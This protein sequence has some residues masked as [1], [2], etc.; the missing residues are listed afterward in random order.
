VQSLAN[1][2]KLVRIVGVGAVIRREQVAVG[3]KRQV[4]GV[5]R[6]A[7]EKQPLGGECGFVIRQKE[8]LGAKTSFQG[9]ASS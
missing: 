3:S 1:P 6:P 8:V 2:V 9:A 7:G 5:A 4:V